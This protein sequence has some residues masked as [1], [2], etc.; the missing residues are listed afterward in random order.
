MRLSKQ[1]KNQPVYFFLALWFC[2]NLFQAYH[3]EL[4]HDEA[5]YWYYSKHLSF[6]YFDHPPAIALIIKIGYFIFKNEL[7]VRLLTVLISA[8]TLAL[9]WKIIKGKKPWLFFLIASSSF[10]VHMGGFIAA[11]DIALVFFSALYF[12]FLKKYLIADTWQTNLLITFAIVGMA[13][14]KYQGAL[15]II[16]SILAHPRLLVRRSTW[17]IFTLTLLAY[18]PH[19]NWQLTNN[20]PTFRYQFIDR[21]NIPYSIGFFF[22]Y[23]GGQL[24]MFGPLTS[25][26]LFF[27]IYKYRTKN[28]WERILKWNLFGIFL[29]FLA[30]SLK[31]RVEANWT[32]CAIIPF[33][34]LSYQCLATHKKRVTVFYYLSIPF[35]IAVLI[36]RSYLIYDFLPSSWVARN[37]FHGWDQWATTIAEKAEDKPVVFHNTFQK[38]SKYLFYAQ[39]SAHSVNTVNYA[40][41]EYDLHIKA[42]E[43]LQGKT[44]FRIHEYGQDTLDTGRTGLVKYDIDSNYHYYNR[45]KIKIPNLS[46]KVKKG[47]TLTIPIKV[48]NRTSKDIDFRKNKKAPSL[49]YCLFWYGKIKKCEPL[50]TTLPFTHLKAQSSHALN[51]SINTPPKSGE[52]WRF[53]LSL[54]SDGFYGR[55]SNFIIFK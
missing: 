19:L 10:L 43:E 36:F 23:I 24:L 7:G 47:A 53:R 29:F 55:N 45:I 51:I 28:V 34:Y 30:Q 50:L 9:G 5:Y 22:E 20:F 3:T 32:V 25:I 38:T 33:L 48:E 21:S 11:P 17:L 35:I 2:L 15:I 14:S 6:G 4:M 39:K 54:E 52:H 27:N 13:Y 16:I 26:L 46:Y 1:L 18:I 44:V 37:E 40:G 31:G 12:Y 8:A 42:E 49:Q 41:K